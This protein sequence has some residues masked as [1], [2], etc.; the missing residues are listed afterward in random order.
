[1]ASFL[2]GSNGAQP[3]LG[4]ISELVSHALLPAPLAAQFGLR[5]APRRTKL[6]LAAF[7][8]VYRRIP[9]S[10]VAIPAY[11]EARRRLQGQGP[12]KWSAWTERQLFGLARRTTAR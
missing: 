6:G 4:R 10:I 3:V 8:Q 12:S 2:I 11:N 9:R 5:G 1:M 7:A